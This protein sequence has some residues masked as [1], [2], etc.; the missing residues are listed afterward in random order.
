MCRGDHREAIFK[1]DDDRLLFLEALGQVCERT[2]WRIHGYVLM[3]NHYHWLLETPGGGLVDGMRW[4]QTTY[5]AR[6]NARHRLCGHLFQGRYKA[7]VMDANEPGYFR[8][9][10][11]YI[12][13]NP[14]RARLLKTASVRLEDFPWSSYPAYVGKAKR[15]VWLETRRVLDSCGMARS[16][17]RQYMQRRVQEVLGG[18]ETLASEWE[19]IRRG[20]FLGGESF[21]EEMRVRI[22]ERMKSRKR[23]SYSGE[24]VKGHDLKRAEELLRKGLNIL[25]IGQEDIQG[26]K[27]TDKRKQALTWLIRSSTQVSCE[28]ICERLGLG[29]RS[30]ISRAVRALESSDRKD[31]RLKMIML[32]CKD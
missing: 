13:L 4:F 26:M 20:W 21:R 9:L 5:T 31:H 11:D 1:G 3:P 15:P 2:G 6:F 22:G 28:W 27:T 16:R 7:I 18:S 32:Q 12:H 29:H 24:E 14:V 8:T 30:N 23:E 10:S 25:K 19:S 17:Y